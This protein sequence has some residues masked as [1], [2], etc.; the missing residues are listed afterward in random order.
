[1][2]K[3]IATLSFLM[4]LISSS[5]AQNSEHLKFKGV[6]IDGTL[7]E[8]V[9]KMKQ[10]GFVLEGTEDGVALLSG[11]FAG[12]SDCV[13]GV[14]TLQKL[15]LVHEIVVLFPPQDKWAGLSYDYERLKTM[16]TKKYGKPYECMEK[17]NAPSYMIEDDNDKMREVVMNNCIYYSTY[18]TDNGSI[19]LTISNDGYELAC[20]VKLF[21]TDKINSEI[22]DNA[23]MEDL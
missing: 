22:F 21:Y 14:K 1:M 4:I 23:A 12:Y 5:F 6:P 17:F 19:T 7:N 9:S 2:K 13:V 15:N 8:Y 20:R 10:A 16:L 3:I 11:E 18:N